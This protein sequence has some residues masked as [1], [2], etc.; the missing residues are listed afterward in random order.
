MRKKGERGRIFLKLYSVTR[1]TK[2]TDIKG[3]IS[4]F[5]VEKELSGRLENAVRRIEEEEEKEKG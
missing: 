2:Y 4:V 3:Y 1:I 5:R